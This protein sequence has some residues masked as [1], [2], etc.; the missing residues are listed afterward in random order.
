M[1]LGDMSTSQ[2]L[3]YVR[4]GR[5]LGQ[6]PECSLCQSRERLAVDHLVPRHLGGQDTRSNY[7]LLCGSCNSS[8]GTRCA[9]YIDA[10]N[11]RSMFYHR[12]V[13]WA[14]EAAGIL[15]TCYLCSRI[16]AFTADNEV[17]ADELERIA[18]A[19]NSDIRNAE[20]DSFTRRLN[21]KSNRREAR[22]AIHRDGQRRRRA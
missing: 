12:R 17:D 21:L 11:V 22:K 14:W 13:R 7:G 1:G 4:A 15:C 16:R 6:K 8:K 3:R 5:I 10:S 9:P 2:F 18:T 20:P 19:R